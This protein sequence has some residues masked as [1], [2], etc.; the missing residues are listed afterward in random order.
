MAYSQKFWYYIFKGKRNIIINA[1]DIYTL[2]IFKN[3]KRG[4]KNVKEIY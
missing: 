4:D 1:V 2:D 3:K